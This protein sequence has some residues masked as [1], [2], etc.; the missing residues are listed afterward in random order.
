VG[1][2]KVLGNLMQM[3]ETLG[4]CRNAETWTDMMDLMIDFEKR[5]GKRKSQIFGS[6]AQEPVSNKCF[7][8]R[9]GSKGVCEL[10]WGHDT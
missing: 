3:T 6:G 8:D 4:N 7:I 2:C 1:E 10:N 9:P 5:E